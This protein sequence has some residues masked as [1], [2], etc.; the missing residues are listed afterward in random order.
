MAKRT[1]QTCTNPINNESS[2]DHYL[3]IKINGYDENILFQ[4]QNEAIIKS[5]TNDM[6]KNS[7]KNEQVF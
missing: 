7:M 6:H 5:M 4:N 2:F 3:T 1:I